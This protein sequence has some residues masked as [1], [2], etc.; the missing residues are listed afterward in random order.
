MDGGLR[1]HLTLLPAT[2]FLRRLPA[3]G[4]EMAPGIS[5]VLERIATKF[6][7]LHG[8]PENLDFGAFWGLRNHVRTVSYILNVRGQGVNLGAPGT[9]PP[10]PT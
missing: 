9:C 1:I 4:G 10:S 2:V 3:T 8:A 7:R 5:R 6:Q